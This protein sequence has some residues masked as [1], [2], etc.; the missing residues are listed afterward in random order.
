M[1]SWQPLTLSLTEL[2]PPFSQQVSI[3]THPDAV[4]FYRLQEMQN[5]ID[6]SC[7]LC[8]FYLLTK[9]FLNEE[10]LTFKIFSFIGAPHI[11]S[12]RWTA[13]TK[14]ETESM[15]CIWKTAWSLSIL[16]KMNF[17]FNLK[18]IEAVR[19]YFVASY[20]AF[21]RGYSQWKLIWKREIVRSSSA[22]SIP[23]K[24]GT[25]MTNFIHFWGRRI[26]VP[27]SALACW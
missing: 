5:L 9:E 20:F 18:E 3:S 21:L 7:A 11:Y 13:T 8:V 10:I 19:C 25:H 17:F 15:R 14:I 23:K 4:I 2:Q 22:Y 1:R 12:F 27:H 16:G 24:S 26:Q 6:F